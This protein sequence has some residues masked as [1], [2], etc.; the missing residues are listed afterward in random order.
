MANILIRG[1]PMEPLCARPYCGH[2][3]SDHV[4]EE[5]NAYCVGQNVVNTPMHSREH[6]GCRCRRFQPP[7]VEYEECA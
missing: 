7:I 6:V 4:V 1:V 3:E 5:D 2:P